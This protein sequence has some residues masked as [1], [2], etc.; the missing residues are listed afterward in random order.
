MK[1]IES[2][3]RT[4]L[5]EMPPV[6]YQVEGIRV[7][8]RTL[9]SFLFSTDIAL[10]RNTNA[11]A[12]LAM[13]PFATQPIIHRSLLASS[14]QPVFVGVGSVS[15]PDDK[16]VRLA[17]DAED[18]GASGIVLGPQ[19]PAEQIRRLKR[20]IDL[21]LIATVASRK[22][23]IE[24]K[25]DGGADILNVSGAQET[26]DIVAMIKSSFSYMP[27]IATGGPTEDSILRTIKAGADAIT[28]TPP[29]LAEIFS[30]QMEILRGQL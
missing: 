29:S 4:F 1:E 11:D 14:E 5:I 12:V 7:F 22:E 27:V 26:P 25:V 21:P 8:G 28:F 19:V 20:S 9:R 30:K 18:A 2:R 13:Y 24:S 17:C 6:I 16:L 15:M 23:D 10:I 3:L